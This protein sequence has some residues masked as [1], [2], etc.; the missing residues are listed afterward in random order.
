M[1]G[2]LHMDLRILCRH[3]DWQVASTA[4]ILGTLSPVLSVIE[5]LTLDHWEHSRSSE[6]HNKVDCAQWR[7]LL[8][9]FSNVKKLLVP[10]ELVGGLSHSL[11]SGDREMP[12]ELLPNLLKLQY[13]GGSNVDD[14]F[15]PF[16][17]ERQAAG[18]PV[19]LVF[20][21]SRRE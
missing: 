1:R 7:K 2:D 10:N 6:W 21:R 12:L 16:I 20:S 14:A 18:H 19:C 8:R 3:L 4:Q 13:F 17:N 9:P 15:T 5:E 11:C